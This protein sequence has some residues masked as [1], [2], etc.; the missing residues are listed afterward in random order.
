MK[1]LSIMTRSCLGDP[2]CREWTCCDT[3]PSSAA[4]RERSFR[5]WRHVFNTRTDQLVILDVFEGA[6][7]WQTFSI[8]PGESGAETERFCGDWS[9]YAELANQRFA[10]GHFF[11]A[12]DGSLLPV[13]SS[14]RLQRMGQCCSTS[15]RCTMDC[16]GGTI[17]EHI[18]SRSPITR[19]CDDKRLLSVTW[20]L[21]YK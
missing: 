21:G 6:Y 10:A 5:S 11:A 19:L 7:P 17:S 20:L 18:S 13:W 15:I 1:L 2:W 14:N 12:R 3:D 4:K 8:E 9:S 16:Q